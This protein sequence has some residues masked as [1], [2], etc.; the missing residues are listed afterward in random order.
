[1]YRAD[2]ILAAMAATG[3]GA[4]VDPVQLQIL[5]FLIDREIP[6]LVGGPHFE[7]QP[8][9]VGPSD[10]SVYDELECLAESGEVIVDGIGSYPS[11][12]LSPTGHERGLSALKGVHATVTEYLENT[13]WWVISQPLGIV[14]AALYKKFPDVAAKRTIGPDRLH[15]P[16]AAKRYSIHPFVF[17]MARAIDLM[18]TLDG[19]L[20]AWGKPEFEWAGMY[21]DWVAAG[22][23]LNSAFQHAS[24]EL[25]GK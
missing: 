10:P 1:M 2:S 12:T 14:L 15:Y 20:S 13:A 25:G 6:T 21:S 7:F 9:N 19:H 23:D 18:G 17:G 11:C 24:V 4:H 3:E 5:L 22:N 8:S 16:R